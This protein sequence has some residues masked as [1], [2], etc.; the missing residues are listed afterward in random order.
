MDLL[1]TLIDLNI[2]TGHLTKN[3]ISAWCDTDSED[4][5]YLLNWLCN[6]NKSNILS[7]LEKQEHD[8][9]LKTNSFINSEEDCEK[10]LN[11]VLLEYPSLLNI[12]DN[13]LDIQL[14]ETEIEKLLEEETKQEM[15]ISKSRFVLNTMYFIFCYKFY[16]CAILGK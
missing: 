11:D 2:E 13:L 7:P 14:L 10:Q 4:D 16:S 9:I 1:E 8:L 3:A 6:L 5:I 12:D 15:L